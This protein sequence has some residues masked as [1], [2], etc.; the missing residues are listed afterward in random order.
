MTKRKPKLC[1]LTTGGTIGM[2]RDADGIARPPRTPA[3]WR[4]V[5][6]QLEQNAEI[7]IVE[8]LNKDSTNVTPA[9]WSLIA[10]AVYERWDDYDGF[11]IVHGTDTMHY[12]ASALALALGPP[13]LPAPVVL[14]GAQRL[15]DA[16]DADGP[17]N[18]LFAGAIAAEREVAE[19]V[20]AFGGRVLRGCRAEKTDA[21]RLLAFDSPGCPL[22][23]ELRKQVEWNTSAVRRTPGAVRPVRS[24]YAEFAERVLP[25][26]VSPG[27]EPGLFREC[28]HPERINGVILRTLGAGNVPN[29]SPHSWVDF[30]AEATRQDIPVLLTSPF[31]AGSTAGSVYA[32]GREAAEAG[33]IPTGNLTAAC[34][35]VKF[36]W[37]IARAQHVGGDLIS[38]VRSVMD[39]VWVGEMDA[40]SATLPA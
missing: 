8:L 25:I 23:G 9:D 40:P 7:D 37:A 24:L 36:R 31:P 4:R 15:P 16:D 27:L 39:R 30:I 29:M 35:E 21:H 22:L 28:L 32:P 38:Q 34:A 12:S 20:I 13:P 19:V 5:A 10:N 26:P 17:T 6:P 14:T 2:V 33:A 11:M 18:L 3:D 1:L